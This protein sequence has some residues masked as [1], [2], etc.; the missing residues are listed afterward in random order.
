MGFNVYGIF[1]DMDEQRGYD[2]CCILCSRKVASSENSISPKDLFWLHRDPK[3]QDSTAI[4]HFQGLQI[5]LGSLLTSIFWR[6][7]IRKRL[8]VLD[9]PRDIS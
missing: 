4:G 9:N 8:L 2:S 7:V 3:G 6:W 5:A 1:N